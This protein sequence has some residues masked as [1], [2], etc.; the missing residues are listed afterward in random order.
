MRVL[1]VPFILLLAACSGTGIN[2]S[3]AENSK[4]T[5]VSMGL[6]DVFLIPDKNIPTLKEQALLGSMQATAQIFKYYEM[7]RF[8]QNQVVYWAEIGT[9]ICNCAAG[10]NYIAT[11]REGNNKDYAN[12]IRA[13][14]WAEQA[15]KN[16]D[17]S[18]NYTLGLINKDLQNPNL[19]HS[20]PHQEKKALAGSIKAALK[21]ADQSRANHDHAKELYWTH[22]AV[23]NGDD[24]SIRR[25]GLLMQNDS[26]PQNQIRAKYWLGLA[27][28]NKN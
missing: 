2:K 4:D 20:L 10:M 12:L 16:G 15:I 21:L 28:K 23:Q 22:I 19:P 13:R 8:D 7:A 26:D 11:Y 27:D 9:E 6:N 24:K 14:F 5:R 1:L 18:T 3:H 25:L 17:K